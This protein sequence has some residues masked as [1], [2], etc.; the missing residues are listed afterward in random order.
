M[1]VE[2]NTN[3]VHK[4]F[5]G[6]YETIWKVDEYDDNGN[7]LEVNYKH[8][9]LL[10]SIAKEYQNNSQKIV[11]EIGCP[12]L[13]S[14]KFLGTFYSPSEYNFST[15]TLDFVA[16]LDFRL[17]RLTLL[18]ELNGDA[19]FQ[20]FLKDN[21][22]SYDG[23]WSHT[24]NNY[25]DLLDE[26]KT[27]GNQYEQAIGALLSYYSTN[28]IKGNDLEYDIYD[29]WQGNGYGGLDYTIVPEETNEIE[30]PQQVPQIQESKIIKLK[31]I[32]K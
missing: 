30:T 32:L 20:T 19:N 24:P 5:S 13:K 16:D 7:E 9:D 1:R 12:F 25:D 27:K 10:K 2:L 15:D 21:Y 8:D 22:S 29:D 23:F 4:L 18:N 14:V 28:N 6:T 11:E 31:N 17:M 26:I 3:L